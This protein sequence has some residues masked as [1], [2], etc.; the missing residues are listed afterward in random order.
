MVHSKSEILKTVFLGEGFKCITYLILLLIQRMQ[1]IKIKE[2]YELQPTE[3]RD[4][5]LPIFI[6][7]PA[8]LFI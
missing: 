3:D 4:N 6:L 7:F 8:V 5:K 2:L 1:S